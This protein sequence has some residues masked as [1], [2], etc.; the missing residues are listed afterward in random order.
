MYVW[1]REKKHDSISRPTKQQQTCIN[2]KKLYK[3]YQLWVV[4][5]CFVA[6]ISKHLH[7][8]ISVQLK[9]DQMTTETQEGN[10]QKQIS[11]ALQFTCLQTKRVLERDQ[12]CSAQ[13]ASLCLLADRVTSFIVGVMQNPLTNIYF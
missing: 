2:Q 3:H 11:P 12:T 7:V 6:F 1:S 4:Q 9:K 8:I 13:K 5:E 10:G